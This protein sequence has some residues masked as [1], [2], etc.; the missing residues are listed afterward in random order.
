MKRAAVILSGGG[1]RRMG[2]DKAGLTLEGTCFLEALAAR[3]APWFDGVYL[4]T[5]RPGRYVLPGVEEVPD[6]RP[7]AQGPLAGLEAALASTGA[8]QI[9]LTAVDLPLGTPELALRLLDGLEG[10]DACCIRR[11]SGR[12]EPLFAAYRARCLPA[13]SACL[14]G[15]RRAMAALLERVQLR[16]LEEAELP[17][18][19]LERQLLNVNRP[20]D[21][22][23]ARLFLKKPFTRAL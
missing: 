11:R 17:G 10:A 18:F 4:S 1:S 5:D 23:R 8:E 2:R 3:Y 15:G 20:E 12:L 7:G 6:L 14:D 19:D 22:E 16:V 13:A 9:F 21:L